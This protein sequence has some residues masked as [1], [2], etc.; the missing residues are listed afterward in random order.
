MR[1]LCDTNVR[2]I[3]NYMYSKAFHD[4]PSDLSQLGAYLSEYNLFDAKFYLDELSAACGLSEEATLE[5]IEKLVSVHV[6][7]V[8]RENNSTCY[9]FQKTKAVETAVVFAVVERLVCEQMA[10]GCGYLIGHGTF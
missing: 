10:W 8:S 4:A 3:L 7:E 2:I 9:I 5:A 1:K 6:V